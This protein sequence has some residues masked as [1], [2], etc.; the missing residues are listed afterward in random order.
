MATIKINVFR[1]GTEW[2]CARWIDGEYDGC[3][4]LEISN[5][6]SDAEAIEA[7]QNL[8]LTVPGERNVTRVDDI[9]TAA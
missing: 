9:N 7:A 2:F 6:A 3:D 8:L 1:D 5:D 4:S